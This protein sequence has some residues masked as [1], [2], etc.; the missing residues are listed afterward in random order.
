MT[1]TRRRSDYSV[2]KTSVIS[3]RQQ[4]WMRT[5]RW[6]IEAQRGIKIHYPF[7]HFSLSLYEK[8]GY[9]VQ[10]WTFCPVRTIAQRDGP[11]SQIW[12][13]LFAVISL[14]WCLC[15][16]LATVLWPTVMNKQAQNNGHG[17]NPLVYTQMRFAL[18]F[19]HRAICRQEK[20]RLSK[21]SARFPARKR[22]HSQPPEL[23]I[24]Q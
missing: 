5:D 9:F 13:Q 14:K 10:S 2:R 7:G 8:N 20:R 3:R 23:R 1:Q 4:V 18:H 17:E 22:W 21:S 11:D 19:Q 24:N 6:A 15:C 12:K 16:C